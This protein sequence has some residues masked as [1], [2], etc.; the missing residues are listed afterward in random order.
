MIDIDK[1]EELARAATPGPWHAVDGTE[2]GTKALTTNTG[3]WLGTIEDGSAL[4]NGA[5]AA[6]IAAARNAV[7]ELIERVRAAEGLL[8]E[9]AARLSRHRDVIDQWVCDNV[10]DHFERRAVEAAKP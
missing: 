10:I 4:R 9:A 1:L 5:D 7:P 8:A 2:S 6:F 3:A